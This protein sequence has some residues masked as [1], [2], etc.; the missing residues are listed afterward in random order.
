MQRPRKTSELP[1]VLPLFPLPG[2]L[3]LPRGRLPLNIFEPRYLSMIDDALGGDRLI[4]MIQPLRS[5]GESSIG[6]ELYEVGCAGRLTSFS[7]TADGRYLITLTGLVR[8]RIVETLSTITPYRQARVDWDD[9]SVDLTPADDDD[10][11]DR[12]GLLAVLKDYLKAQQLEADWETIE[13]APCETLINSLA[14]ICPF[15]PKEKQAL[16]E[17]PA[18][19]DRA[20]TLLA[21]MEFAL[22]S[23]GGDAEPSLQ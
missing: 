19:A 6:S 2:A 1:E 17:A 7:E 11:P 15:D 22:A 5:S 23:S 4:G 3:L 9:F 21:L 8:F 13:D 20:Q 18:L 12:A 16:L 14:M 10:V